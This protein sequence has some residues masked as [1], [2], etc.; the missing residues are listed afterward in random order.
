LLVELAGID[1][2]DKN[3]QIVAEAKRLKMDRDY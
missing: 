3:L 1:E 2:I